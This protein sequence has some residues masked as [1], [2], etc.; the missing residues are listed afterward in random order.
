M[1]HP[2]KILLLCVAVLASSCDVLKTE[3]E[4]GTRGRGAQA[5]DPYSSSA[6]GAISLSLLGFNGCAML[7]TGEPVSRGSLELE[8]LD[9]YPDTCTPLNSGIPLGAPVEPTARFTISSGAMYFLREF[10]VVDALVNVHTDYNDRRTPVGWIRKESRFKNLD[11]SGLSV[12]RDEWRRWGP[13]SY[14]RE[15]FYENAAW[16]LSTDDT[17]LIEVADAD[18]NVRVSETYSRKDFLSETPVTGRT[19]VSWGVF[20]VGRP[21]YPGDPEMHSL[22]DGTPYFLTAAKVSFANSTNPFKSFRMPD[23]TG[24]GFIRV[25]W[26]QLPEEPFLFPVTFVKE[27]DKEATCFKLDANGLATNEQV[28]CGFGLSQQVHINKPAN[29]KYFEPGETVDFLISLNDGDGNGLHSRDLMPSYNQY[30]ADQ[31]NGLAYFNEWMI[32]TYRDTSASESG[33]KVVGPLHELQAMRGSYA[34]PYYSFPETS[35]PKFFVEPGLL[36]AIAGYKDMQPSTRYGVT[37]PADAKPGTYA[38]VLKG[39]RYFMGERLNRMDPFFFQVGQEKP[40]T[41]PGDIGNCQVCHN[42]VSSLNNLHHGASVD[43][44]ELCKT[45][46]I[47]SSNGH[48][49]DLIHRLHMGSNK[50][51]Q[52]KADCRMCHLTRE[53]AVRPS[54]AACGSCH[55]SVHGTDYFDLKFQEPEQTPNANGNC[56]NACH[57]VTPPS[58][59]I[60]PGQ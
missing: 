9:S 14:V 26:S 38:V 43:H 57:A 1:R 35:E 50:Y 54:L 2:Q 21:E 3:D 7:P 22:P 58:Q 59:H 46:H 29:G 56:A 18:G 53:P 31:S 32:L 16:M 24:E 40:T 20:G 28:P 49:S 44:V 30:I 27:L 6:S 10:S 60:L 51:K 25:T 52:S 12:G 42:G 45:C 5:F 41:Y 19:R 39:R 15:T 33:F 13:G 36:Q 11:W 37:L 55:V 47:D 4:E 34:L 48:I 8:D 17:F 23:L